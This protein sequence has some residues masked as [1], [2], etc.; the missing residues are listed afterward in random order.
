MGDYQPVAVHPVNDPFVIAGQGTVMARF[1]DQVV[2][3]DIVI[4]PVLLLRQEPQLVGKWVGVVLTGG[5]VEWMR[6]WPC[7]DGTETMRRVG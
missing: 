7:L 1:V 6:P 4:A 2:D 5:H 3:P